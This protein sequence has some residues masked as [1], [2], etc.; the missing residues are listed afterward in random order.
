MLVGAGLAVRATHLAGLRDL[1]ATPTGGLIFVGAGAVLTASGLPRQVF[2]FAGGYVFGPWTGAALALAG[3]IAGAALDYAAA[4]TAAGPWAARRLAKLQAGTLAR[5]RH[6]LTAHPFS[7]T[8]TLR[9]LPIGNNTA[10]NLLAG[11]AAVP[12]GPFLLA[13]LMGYVPQTA[14]FALLGS[15]V[16]VG[17]ATRLGVAVVL[18]ALS[19][20]LGAILW[21]RVGAHVE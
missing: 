10:L 15:G 9:L 2:A 20:A 19:A 1:P 11:L 13:S 18:F 3:Q 6:M 16:Q 12:L 17:Q 7:T 8:V 5:V 4:Y 21:R 14:I